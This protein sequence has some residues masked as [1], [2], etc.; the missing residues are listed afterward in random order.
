MDQKIVE[1]LSST[2]DEFG[3][4]AKKVNESSKK[5]K[6]YSEEAI[7]YLNLCLEV[8]EVLNE[9]L[10]SITASDKE[11]RNQDT[12]VFNT[13]KILKRNLDN[14][15]SIVTE[16]RHKDELKK[17]MLDQ[18]LQFIKEF[19]DTLEEALSNVTRIIEKDNAI[20]LM[21]NIITKRKQFQHESLLKLKD[22]TSTSLSD[23]EKAIEGSSSNL[24]RGLDMVKKFKN[25]EKFV[26]EKNIQ[27][28]NNLVDESGK[29][30]N[31]A[32]NV[33]KSSSSQF[34]FAE[35]VK[36]FTNDL[37]EDSV[38]IKNLVIQKHHEFEEN[39]QVI[40][41]L[42]VILSIKFKKYLNIEDII[43]EIDLTERNERILNLLAY[44]GAACQDI[45]EVTELNYDMT[46]ASNLNNV[47]EDKF[48]RSTQKEIEYFESIQ[49]E[50]ELMTEATRYPV[51]GSGKNITN[52]QILEE[53]LK[54][55]IGQ[56]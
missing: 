31:I 34:E 5:R 19:N 37:Y 28:L 10:E 33:N 15:K 26:S 20:V 7:N 52:G 30:W 39:L 22:L 55:L 23:A 35:K 11:L 25:V 45:R 14:Q 40:T 50:V 44:I 42:T 47:I 51:E 21:D 17:E 12:I 3:K 41:V 24:G 38:A 6:N 48:V 43:K 32:V 54:E 13:C 8:E 46:D 9:D 36:K 56:L 27:E 1:I 2:A 18:L 4:I 53:K 49:K 29:G 16:L